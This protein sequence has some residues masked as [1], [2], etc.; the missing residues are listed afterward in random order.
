[1]V[2]EI[3]EK[4][5]FQTFD[6]KKMGFYL[7]E[8][9]LDS[10]QEKT[11]TVNIPYAQGVADFSMITGERIFEQRTLTYQFI[12]YGL[13]YSFDRKFL[14]DECRRKLIMPGYGK[15]QDT[16]NPGYFWWGKCEEVNCE[17]DEGYRKCTIDIKFSVYPFLVA[18]DAYFD[19]RW[20]TFDFHKSVSQFYT[21]NIQG[22]EDI[23]IINAGSRSISPQI[24]C[25]NAFTLY[26]EKKAYRIYPG[27]NKTLLRL[28]PGANEIVVKGTGG[29]EIY[30]RIELMV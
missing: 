24:R 26:V 17:D 1:M 5:K 2:V 7:V 10:P 12:I 27:E 9:S 4:L 15:I 6:S 21:F 28:S 20:D 22:A 19:D 18:D 3:R 30:P 11:V 23:V 13:P 29:L 8:R 25:T 16:H 14:E